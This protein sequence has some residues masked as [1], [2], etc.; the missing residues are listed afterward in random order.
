MFKEIVC[1]FSFTQKVSVFVYIF[2]LAVLQSVYCRLC[3]DSSL[4]MYNLLT[5]CK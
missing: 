4:H 2:N 3:L 1:A 5:N